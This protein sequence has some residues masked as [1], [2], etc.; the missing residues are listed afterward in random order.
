M[1]VNVAI[2]LKYRFKRGDV[3]REKRSLAVGV[4]VSDS[5][6]AQMIWVKMFLSQIF[7]SKSEDGIVS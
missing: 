3:I 5:L 6:I 2:P 1:G 4:V 7:L